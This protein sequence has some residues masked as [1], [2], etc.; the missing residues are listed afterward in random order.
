MSDYMSPAVCGGLTAIPTSILVV[1]QY[2][3]GRG[4]EN[5]NKKILQPACEVHQSL[6]PTQPVKNLSRRTSSV[7]VDGVEVQETGR[8]DDQSK[9]WNISPCSCGLK[10]MAPPTVQS[11]GQE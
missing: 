10:V 7:L 8:A 2:V 9:T 5:R 11:F 3:G 4:T 1:Y 6:S